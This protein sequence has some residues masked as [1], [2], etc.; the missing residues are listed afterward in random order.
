MQRVLG[1]ELAAAVQRSHT[2]AG[3]DFTI[4]TGVHSYTGDDVVTGVVLG[5]GRTIAADIVVEAVGSVCNVEW[6]DGQGLDLSD[7]VLTDNRLAVAG[8]VAAVAVGDIAR[9]PNPLFDDVPRRVEHWSIPTD[10]AKRAA[11]TVLGSLD[12]TAPFAPIPSFW[13]NQLDLRLQSYGSPSLADEVHL[14]EGAID[15]LTGGVIATYHRDRRHVGT[16]AVNMSPARH[17]ELRE[18]FDAKAVSA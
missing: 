1:A 3:I 16:V 17:R 9:F 10:T 13:S 18:A 11:A 15:D 7:G 8:A 5:T 12:N 4:G 14:D 6:L 2:A